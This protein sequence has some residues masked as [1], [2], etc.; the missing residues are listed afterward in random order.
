MP[1]KNEVTTAPA[2]PFRQFLIDTACLD[3]IRATPC[4]IQFTVDDPFA[5]TDHAGLIMNAVA[6]Q[7]LKL[8]YTVLSYEQFHFIQNMLFRTG[9]I[10]P[11]FNRW[12]AQKVQREVQPRAVEIPTIGCLFE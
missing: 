3:S 12:M 9:A 11:F 1:K 4:Y 6:V 5:D 8:P 2:H 10:A 7:K